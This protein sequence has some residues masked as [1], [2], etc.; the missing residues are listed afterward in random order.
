MPNNRVLSFGEL[1]IRMQ[2]TSDYFFETNRNT[3]KVYPGGSEANVAVTLARLGIPT[4]YLSAAPDNALTQEILSKLGNYGIDTSLMKIQGDRLGSYFL[5]SANG[6]SKG[7]VI[8]DRKYSSF[9]QLSIDD[10]NWDII[11][12]GIDWF[13]FTAL[14]PSLNQEL[15]YICKQALQKAAE[16]G[17][18]ISVDLNYRNRLWQ[19]G[20]L[21]NEIMPELVQYADVIMGNIWAANK[22]L[23]SPIDETLD[24][25]TSKETYVAYSKKSAANIFQSYP[26]CKHI[27][28]TFRFMDNATHN[29]FYGTYHSRETDAVSETLETNN[30]IDRIG[31]GDAFMGGLIYAV[32]QEQSPQ[33][34]INTAT[35]AGFQKLFVEGDFG[36]G[37]I[38]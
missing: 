21:P 36:N 11:F 9:S 14:T 18:T 3:L 2:A 38:N 22:M 7:E 16:R 17:I 6:L 29:L 4:T 24:R 25:Q 20:K 32:I 37:K 13:H 26:K 12:E 1:L 28:N 34:I 27:A 33:D 31:S 5:L 35:Q 23:N 10:I 30:V 19:Y 15:A 8:Y